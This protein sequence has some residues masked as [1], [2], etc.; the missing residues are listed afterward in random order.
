MRKYD[1]KKPKLSKELKELKK[2]L[3]PK[4]VSKIPLEV[5]LTTNI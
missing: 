5:N 4:V 3:E 1:Y 2:E